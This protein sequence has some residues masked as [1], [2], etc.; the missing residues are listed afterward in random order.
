MAGST[1]PALVSLAVHDPYVSIRIF[2]RELMAPFA[3]GYSGAPKTAADINSLFHG[4]EMR[5]VHARRIPTQ[6]VKHETFG[7]R[8]NESFV[9]PAVG[10]LP[11]AVDRDLPIPRADPGPLP[12]PAS[13]RQFNPRRRCELSL[14]L[15]VSVMPRKKSMGLPFAYA[16]RL[17]R[18]LRNGG[19]AAASAFAQ[20]VGAHTMTLINT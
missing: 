20:P 14:A 15:A 16:S 18:L 9:C 19:L 4:F 13:V 10:Q 11:S 7:D 8:A 17:V 2:W 12:K 1:F 3:V 6:M 5:R